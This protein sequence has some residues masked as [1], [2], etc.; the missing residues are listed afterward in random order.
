MFCQTNSIFIELSLTD[1]NGL[2]GTGARERLFSGGG[3]KM[4]ICLVIAK[5]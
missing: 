1:I 4:C 5:I 3:A 2:E